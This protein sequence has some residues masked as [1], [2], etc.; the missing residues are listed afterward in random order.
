LD[1]SKDDARLV[2]DSVEFVRSRA[3]PPEAVGIGST[4]MLFLCTAAA[5]TAGRSDDVSDSGAELRRLE[6]MTAAAVSVVA[7]ATD[8]VS[9]SSVMEGRLSSR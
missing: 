6:A 2:S 9:D 7:S 3:W 4:D 8:V 5:T 1:V